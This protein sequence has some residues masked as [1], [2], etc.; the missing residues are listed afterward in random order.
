MAEFLQSLNSDVEVF[1]TAT[2]SRADLI[3]RDDQPWTGQAVEQ[4]ARDVRAGYDEA[5]KHPGIK[6]INAAGEAWNRAFAMG[7]ADANPY[8]GIDTDKFDLW[9][10]DHYHASSYGY[11]LEALVVFGNITGIDPR[12]L[13][14]DECSGFEL[15][16]SPRQI[17]ML[18]QA[19]FDQLLS[20]GRIKPRALEQAQSV[21]GAPCADSIGG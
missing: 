6:S 11:Y 20:D 5:A 2:W 9:T 13:G 17:Q 19:A 10:Y 16:M 21:S 1:L 3:Y 12:A 8:D 18:Q 14:A 7:I 15:G 4:M